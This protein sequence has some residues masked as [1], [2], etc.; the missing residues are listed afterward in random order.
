MFYANFY[1]IRKMRFYA[2][3]VY[4][5]DKLLVAYNIGGT[6]GLKDELNNVLT[7]DRMPRE[8]V[9][10]REFEVELKKLDNPSAF[11]S[12]KS[13]QV[14]NKI[15]LLINLRTAAIAAMAFIFSWRLIADFINRKKRV[16]KQELH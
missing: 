9:L 10:A 16:E 11:L 3:Q 14:K 7:S 8:L 12:E 1:A 2:T 13:T 6:E 15:R 4:L 5:Y